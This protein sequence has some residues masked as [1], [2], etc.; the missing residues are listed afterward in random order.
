MQMLQLIV[1][2]SGLSIVVVWGPLVLCDVLIL[3][4]ALIKNS[5]LL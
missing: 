2:Q 3:E 1:L 4:V 5:G